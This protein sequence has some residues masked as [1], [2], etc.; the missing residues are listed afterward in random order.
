MSL[1]RRQ[2]ATVTAGA[3]LTGFFAPIATAQEKAVN[4][5]RAVAFDALV[6]F[7]PRSI[8]AM[9]KETFGEQAAELVTLWRTRQ[10]EYTWLRVA[11]GRYA[12]FWQVTGDALGFAAQSLRIDLPAEKRSRLMQGFLQL[13][14]WPGVMEGLASLRHAGLRLA[15]LSN[16]TPEMLA[17]CIKTSALEDAFDFRLSTDLIKTYKPDPHA[18]A[19]AVEAFVLP[20]QEIAFA[21]FGGWDAF[22]AKSFGYKTFWFN[23]AGQPFEELGERPDAICASFADLVSHVQS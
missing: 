19:M 7:D 8:L 17:A 1:T 20:V 11:S 5:T 22:G 6:I 15:L 2:I 16:F 3:A 10:F 14:P 13:K 12:D 4:G 9:A 23:P 21:A 18:Y